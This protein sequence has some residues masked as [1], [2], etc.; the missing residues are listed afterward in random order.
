VYYADGSGQTVHAF[1]ADSGAELWH[2]AAGA[3]TGDAFSAPLVLDG[4]VYV[5]SR[6]GRLHAFGLPQ[7]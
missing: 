1:D 3:I 6:E 4:R 5:S 2:S 7:H